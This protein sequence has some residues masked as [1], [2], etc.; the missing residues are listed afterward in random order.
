[1]YLRILI[2]HDFENDQTFN[3]TITNKLAENNS[4]SLKLWYIVTM[5]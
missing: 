2:N 5:L 4:H 1:M 3:Q